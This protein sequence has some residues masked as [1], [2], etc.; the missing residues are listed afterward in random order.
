M[1]GHIASSQEVGRDP[2][3]W[4][5]QLSLFSPA[6]RV[7][8]LAC[9]ASPFLVIFGS[10]KLIVIRKHMAFYDNRGRGLPVKTLFLEKLNSL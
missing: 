6:L 5:P 10:V 3:C 8:T 7:V 9:P 2:C 4:S 1:V